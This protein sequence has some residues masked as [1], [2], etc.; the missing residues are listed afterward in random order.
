[1]VQFETPNEARRAIS[2]LQDN[3]FQGRPI[4]IREDREGLQ[5]NNPMM[6]KGY[7]ND[8][9]MGY[10][11]EGGPTNYQNNVNNTPK[12]QRI[13]VGNVMYYIILFYGILLN[14]YYYSDI[15][16]IYNKYLL[17]LA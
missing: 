3:Q 15:N 4:H 5:Y 14:C 16:T 11:N 7:M 8:K 2:D 13:F 17:I 1:M 12:E 6:D 9:Q 10:Q